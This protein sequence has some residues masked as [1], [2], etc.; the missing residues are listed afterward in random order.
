MLLILLLL[1]HTAVVTHTYQATQY[2]TQYD[3]T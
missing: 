3:N 1:L 2:D